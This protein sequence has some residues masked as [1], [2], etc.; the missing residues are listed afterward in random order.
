MKSV[1]SGLARLGEYTVC[2]AF[3]VGFQYYAVGWFAYELI[4]GKTK[5]SD[6]TPTSD[7]KPAAPSDTKEQG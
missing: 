2:A 3:V 6:L 5:W 1:L 4:T 7:A